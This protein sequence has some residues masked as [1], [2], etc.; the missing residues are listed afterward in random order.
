MLRNRAYFR[1][2]ASWHLGIAGTIG[3]EARA[4][5]KKKKKFCIVEKEAAVLEQG[6]D[7]EKFRGK[8]N[9]L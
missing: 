4:K 1:I 3:A 8:S 6:E 9:L 7:E 2:L 5:D